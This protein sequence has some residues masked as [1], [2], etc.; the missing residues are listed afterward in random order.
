MSFLIYEPHQDRDLI[1]S[2]RFLSLLDL[3]AL[4]PMLASY[5]KRTP[6]YP[7][8]AMLRLLAYRVLRGHLY[9]SA[10][11]RELTAKPDL[12]SL[13]GFS[14]VPSYQALWHFINVRLRAE[15]FEKLRFHLL[16]LIREALK[17]QGVGMGL[18]GVVDAT[19]IVSRNH[20]A[21]YN[22]YYKATCYLAHKLLDAAT[23]LTLAWLLTPGDMDEGGLLVTLLCRVRG[24]GFKLRRLYADN[25]YSSPWNYAMLWL[26]RIKPWIGFRRKAK[27]SWRGRLRTLRL[28]YR[29]MIRGRLNA[30]VRTLPL[31]KLL[32]GLMAHGQEEYVGAYIRNLSLTEYKRN[33]P[34][35]LKR[36]RTNRNII[37]GS[38]GHQ[39]IWLRLDRT[40]AKKLQTVKN[41]VSLLFLTEA[42]VAYGRVNTGRLTNLTGTA[43]L[44]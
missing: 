15:G 25:G 21:V 7:L 5:Y 44:T 16:E 33:K 22:G 34:R 30:N 29:K 8:D 11:W 9:L 10:L 32:M 14:R 31:R 36:Y 12:A 24:L 40:P 3:S 17:S 37:E 38:N 26:M 42:L 4:I 13:L 27:P 43:E 28:R 18:E 2:A 20:D 35:W 19:P 6:T 23:G 1:E 41:H 39:K